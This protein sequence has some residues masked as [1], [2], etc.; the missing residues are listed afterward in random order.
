MDP[1]EPTPEQLETYLHDLP[2]VV[3]D[4][5]DEGYWRLHIPDPRLPRP[6]SSLTD[7]G[8]PDIVDVD[9]LC[10]VVWGEVGPYCSDDGYHVDADFCLDC[11]VVYLA[12]Q[13]IEERLRDGLDAAIE[14]D[15][16]E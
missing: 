10:G 7:D 16:D 1:A 6:A 3:V 9:C 12:G 2:R 5:D 11:G 14:E 8:V 15:D 4:Y 13:A